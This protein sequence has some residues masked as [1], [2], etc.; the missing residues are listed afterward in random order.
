MDA[1]TKTLQNGENKQQHTTSR[2]VTF[3]GEPHYDE[4]EFDFAN[5]FVNQP[6]H[7][8][9]LVLEAISETAL[10]YNCFDLILRKN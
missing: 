4:E 3:N 5:S 6:I 2:D 7:T 8:I 10:V 1:I 9:E